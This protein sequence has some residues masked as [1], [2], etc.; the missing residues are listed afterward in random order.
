MW[1]PNSSSSNS[2]NDL[3]TIF[4]SPAS[5]I[6]ES[7]KDSES[8]DDQLRE[9]AKKAVEF[10]TNLVGYQIERLKNGCKTKVKAL[11]HVKIEAK[12]EL[13]EIRKKYDEVQ[14]Q[15]GFNEVKAELL[16]RENEVLKLC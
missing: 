3:L 13:S 10:E 5:P 12:K 15:V 16:A 2:S 1:S 8:D 11:R 9:E 6:L 14:Q 4:S 7:L